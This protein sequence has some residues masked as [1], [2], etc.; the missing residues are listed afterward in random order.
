MKEFDF[1]ESKVLLPPG[2]CS[3]C[4]GEGQEQGLDA[5]EPDGVY[6]KPCSKCNATGKTPCPVCKL[7]PSILAP[8]H[9]LCPRCLGAEIL[10]NDP[11]EHAYEVWRVS[12]APCRIV[13]MPMPRPWA[14]LTVGPR[15]DA[16]RKIVEAIRAKLQ[17]DLKAETRPVLPTDE[18]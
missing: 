10:T 16:W 8:G 18:G 2:A 4:G 14:S 12:I 9:G 11:V 3:N 15:G 1:K 5:N 6:A 13:G 17:Y 7:E